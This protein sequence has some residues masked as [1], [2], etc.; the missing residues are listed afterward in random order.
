[1]T[2][3]CRPDSVLHITQQ[4]SAAPLPGALISMS[5]PAAE[6]PTPVLCSALDPHATTLPPVADNTTRVA[7]LHP[8]VTTPVNARKL[9]KLLHGYKHQKYIIQGI[10]EGF[11]LHFQGPQAP[12]TSKNSHTIQAQINIVREKIQKELSLGR[13]AGPF[14]HPPFPNFKSSPL[15]L[16][17]KS[18]PGKYRLLH[19]LSY[20]Y[21]DQSVNFNI[22]RHY[23][24][25][26]YQ[27]IKEAITLLQHHSPAAFMAKSDI[28]DAFR[29]IPVHP[30][31]YHLL[32]FSLDHKFYY[33]K[34]LAM[35]AAPSCRIFE[36]FSDAI[37]WILREKFSITSV[38]K[39]LDDFLFVHNDPH[40]CRRALHTFVSLCEEIGVPIAHHKT[41]GPSQILT[42][43]G[44]ELDS[45]SM[46]AR[47]P[48]DKLATY[49]DNVRH[50]SHQRTTTLRGLKSV[51]GQLTF[52]T[53]VIPSG[54]AFLRR[55]HNLTISQF[56]PNKHIPL[57]HSSRQDLL[58]WANFLAHHNGRTIIRPVSIVTSAQIKLCADASK[59]GFGATYG[60]AWLQG[61]WPTTWR[62]LHISFL[63]MYPIY[64]TIA[65]FAHKLA[66]SSITFYSD[67]SGVVHIINKQS[68]KCPLIMQLIRPLVLIL[69]Q[70]NIHLKSVHI[71]GVLNIL[72]D[73][74]SRQQVSASLLEQFGA[75]MTPTA[76]PPELLPDNF[77]LSFE[78]Q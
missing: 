30:S 13:I 33:D 10:S 43:L 8:A 38:V 41:E 57:T 48:C 22:P 63:E 35:G 60:A 7:I 4:D 12:L 53:S 62:D 9:N 24:T 52:A 26:K 39:V 74:I 40:Q 55:L 54:R 11:I 68:S 59:T 14:D 36:S 15:A 72:C 67:N 64:I 76:L 19:N 75:D 65:T 73:A 18:T 69:L 21:D 51:I 71:P 47:L 5:V 28:S 49:S 2:K 32:G 31:Q 56:N 23:T 70:H 29:I 27:T 25:V 50:L 20:P 78:Q 66:N 16:R 46:E 1:M 42:F 77:N 61:T 34:M 58:M 44:I 37:L 3:R 45:T 6:G 17:E